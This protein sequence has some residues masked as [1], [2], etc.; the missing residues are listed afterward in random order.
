MS[1]QPACPVADRAPPP[2]RRRRPGRAR[3]RGAAAIAAPLALAL[4][5]TARAGEASEPAAGDRI[6]Y[7]LP[8]DLGI[9]IAAGTLWLGTQLGQEVLAADRCGWCDRNGDGSDALNGLD[10]AARSLRWADP[11]AANTASDVL[12]YV[13]SPASALGLNALAAGLDDRLD[14]AWINSLLIAEA[15]FVASMTTQL[16]KFA[17][18]RE[19]PFVHYR[20]DEVTKPSDNNVSFFSAHTNFS[21]AIAVSSG[22]VASLRGYRHAPWVWAGGL[23]IAAGIGYLRIAADRHYF[24]DVITGAVVGTLSGV[25]VPLLFHAAPAKAERASLAPSSVSVSDRVISATWRF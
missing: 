16:V 8:L 6:T 23:P 9:T 24:T 17:V 2:R 1:P 19:R 11:T 21:F 13:V 15:T 5:L 12:G 3:R 22:M 18:A 7:N 4:A 20:S 25:L 14:E 10:G